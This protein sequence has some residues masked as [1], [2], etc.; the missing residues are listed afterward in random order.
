[1][2]CPPNGRG[3]SQKPIP[4][5]ERLSSHLRAQGIGFVP[6][7]DFDE[8]SDLEAF[9]T[10]LLTFDGGIESKLTRYDYINPG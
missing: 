2:R 4:I 6:L 3:I 9:G 8:P 1:M 7:W 10:T 5:I